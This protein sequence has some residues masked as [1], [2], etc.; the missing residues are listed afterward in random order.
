M[1]ENNRFLNIHRIAWLF[2]CASF[3]YALLLFLYILFYRTEII[4]KYFMN[5]VF[6]PLG[7]LIGYLVIAFVFTVGVVFASLRDEWDSRFCSKIVLI[8]KLVQI[9]AYILIF[10]LGTLFLIT[11]FTFGISLAFV[12]FDVSLIIMTG[13]LGTAAVVRA[14]K[15]GKCSFLWAVFLS[16]SQYIFCIDVFVSLYLFFMVREKTNNIEVQN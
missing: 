10:I 14:Y 12:I 9:P 5:T 11:I 16:V 8:I 6:I 1:K 3:P 2:P 15:E 13:L 4:E 7:I